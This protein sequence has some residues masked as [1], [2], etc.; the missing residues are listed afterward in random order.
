MRPPIGTS[1][2]HGPR[3]AISL[4]TAAPASLR[5]A[6]GDV[7]IPPDEEVNVP[8]PVMKSANKAGKSQKKRSSIMGRILNKEETK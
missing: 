7:A 1:A 2:R 3:V 8:Q 6:E 5:A 4:R